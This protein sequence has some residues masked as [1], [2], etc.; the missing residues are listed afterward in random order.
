MSTAEMKRYAQLPSLEV[1]QGQ[2]VGILGS[3]AQRLA[4]NIQ[5]HQMELSSALGRYISDKSTPEEVTSA[6]E[7]A[8][9]SEN[10]QE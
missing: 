4:H 8:E 2:L 7:A 10:T 9:S 5:Y 3:P 1:L 6:A